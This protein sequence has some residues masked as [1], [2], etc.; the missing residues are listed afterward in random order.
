[1]EPGSVGWIPVFLYLHV[2]KTNILRALVLIGMAGMASCSTKKTTTSETV[3]TQQQ[4]DEIRR[5]ATKIIVDTVEVEKQVT[6]VDQVETFIEIPVECDSLG[7]VRPTSTNVSGSNFSASVAIAAGRLRLEAKTDSIVSVL[8]DRYR[9]R[10]VQDSLE[11]ERIYQEKVQLLQS[12]TSKTVKTRL[13]WWVWLIAAV[14]IL[15][16]VSRFLPVTSWI[17]WIRAR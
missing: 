9:A 10:Y 1:M 15:A 12:E 8:E 3:Y 4:V 6:I 5:N 13:P 17:S 16:V 2:M 7:Q 14:G 11:L